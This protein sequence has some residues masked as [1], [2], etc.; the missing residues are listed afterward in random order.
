L[1]FHAWFNHFCAHNQRKAELAK[2][3]NSEEYKKSYHWVSD[4]LP[5]VPKADAMKGCK[6]GAVE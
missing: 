1:P 6:A 3:R 5:K 4:E 2:A